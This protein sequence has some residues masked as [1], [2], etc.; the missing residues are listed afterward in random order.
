LWVKADRGSKIQ[1]GP[2]T[3]NPAP[4]WFNKGDTSRGPDYRTWI[5]LRNQAKKHQKRWRQRRILEEAGITQC[6]GGF[7]HWHPTRDQHNLYQGPDSHP[8]NPWFPAASPGRIGMRDLFRENK[9]FQELSAEGMSSSVTRA[10]ISAFVAGNAP[11][12]S[13]K[14]AALLGRSARQGLVILKAHKK[15]ASSTRNQGHKNNPKHYGITQK[16]LPGAAVKSGQVLL[17]QKGQVWKA[18]ANVVRAKNFTLHALKDGIVQW[19]GTGNKDGQPNRS[20]GGEVFVVPWEYVHSKCQWLTDTRLGPK[21]YEPWMGSM[22]HGDYGRGII[23]KMREEWLQT[24]E[25]KAHIKKKEEKLQKQKE[26]QA[27]IRAHAKLR[28]DGKA[29]SKT[30]PVLAGGDSES[31]A[32]A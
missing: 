11:M 31:D 28:R 16:G 7:K 18:G 5:N 20:G 21:Q 25:G 3:R 14:R 29:P 9:A 6:K 19:R 4:P 13:T 23:L 17:K 26:I 32:D 1:R 24:E 10:E 27:R 30:E 15:A 2:W 22:K 8:D 12:L